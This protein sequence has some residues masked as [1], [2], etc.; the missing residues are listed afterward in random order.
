MDGVTKRVREVCW[1]NDGFIL[2]TLL[3]FRKYWS[4]AYMYTLLVVYGAHDHDNRGKAKSFVEW[5][6]LPYTN[7]TVILVLD[8]KITLGKYYQTTC[9]RQAWSYQHKIQN[10][11][12]DVFRMEYLKNQSKVCM[13]HDEKYVKNEN[14]RINTY[15]CKYQSNSH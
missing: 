11:L 1:V 13:D 6:Q 5:K 14:I 12:S 10:S 9:L 8:K 15:L 2:M 7:K 4:K 3:V